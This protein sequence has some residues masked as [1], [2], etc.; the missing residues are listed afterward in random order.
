MHGVNGNEALVDE[1]EPL[2]T[3]ERAYAVVAQR[4]RDFNGRL[5]NVHV[6]RGVVFGGESRAGFER[7]VVYRVRRVRRHG[8]A[9][10][11][12][13]LARLEHGFSTLQVF[14][15]ILGPGGRKTNDEGRGCAAQTRVTQTACGIHREEV[16]VRS[17]RD[18]ACRHFEAGHICAVMHEART[19]QLAFCRPDFC[20]EPVHERKIGAEP[21]HEVHRRVRVQIHEAGHDE[22]LGQRNDV[23]GLVLRS[24]FGCRQDRRNVAA[25]DDD[26]LVF[27]NDAFGHDGQNPAGFNDGVDKLH[28]KSLNDRLCSLSQGAGAAL[29]GIL[30]SRFADACNAQSNILISL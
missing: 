11:L 10:K 28:L 29:G 18:A 19:H 4:I 15:I 13:A 17:R 30:A 9:H 26:A 23:V 6:N 8:R 20:C 27:K 1:T 14:G 21:A 22:A 5:M 3:L 24:G 2:E 25:F 7:F 16:V 12:V